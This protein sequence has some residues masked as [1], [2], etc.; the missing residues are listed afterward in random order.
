MATPIWNTAHADPHSTSLTPTFVSSTYVPISSDTVARGKGT[1]LTAV[2]AEMGVPATDYYGNPRPTS[3]NWTI[4]AF[5][6]VSKP[7]P[8]PAPTPVPTP[9]A[10]P[11]PTPIPIP[12]PPI[13]T[14]KS[15]PAPTP[16]EEGMWNESGTVIKTPSGFRIDLFI[17]D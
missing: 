17:D 14:P 2:F 3:G 15:T 12:T 5:E 7:T 4:G 11:A 13:P 10:T 9:T 8:V 6:D 1:N 16:I